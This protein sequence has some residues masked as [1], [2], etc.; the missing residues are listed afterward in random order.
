MYSVS[1]AY[2][3]QMMKNAT[4][5]RLTGTIGSVAFT[6]DDVV[7]GSFE[8]SGAATTKSDTKIGGVYIGELSFMFV[9][10]FLD[11]VARNQYK[12]KEI[13]VSIGLM[14][15]GSWIDI[16]VGVYT[17]QAPKISKRGIEITAY[18][19]MAKLDKKFNI[20]ATSA[21]PWGYLSY[22]ATHCSV[23]LGITRAEV[24]A[25]PNGTELLGLYQEN[26]IET[27]RDLLYWVA[28]TLGC[29]ACCD[30]QGQI[31]LRKFG[32]PTGVTFDSDHRD[33]DIVF[34][35]YETKWTGVSFV[36]IET[37]MTRYYGLEVDD[38]LTMNMGANPLLQVGSI[39]AINRRRINVLNAVAQIRYTPFSMNAAR[40]PIFD[41]GDE[42][43]FEGGISGDCTGCVMAYEYSLD[44]FAFEGYGDDPALANAR[45]KTD[46]NI[47]GLMQNTTENEVTYHQYVNLEAITF[48]SDQEVSL[49]KLR[50]VSAQLTTVKILHE[51]IFDMLSD[52][53]S[54]GSYELHYYLDGELLAYKPGERT[55]GIYG[56][57][58]GTSEFS[59]CRDFFYVI[60]DVEPGL[61]HTWEVKIITHGINLT[62]IDAGNAHVVLEG[63]RM[64]GEDYFGG[65][66]EAE[67]VIIATALGYLAVLP[68]CD[69]VTLELLN[70]VF[71]AATD[72][73]ELIDV[74]SFGLIQIREG[75]GELSPHIFFEG[76]L[77][78]T[79]E[80]GADLTTES[81]VDLITD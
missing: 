56:A 16:P 64:Y 61:S 54:E 20:D 43:L 50:F 27:D 11:K 6:G 35:G 65:V 39:V 28:Q 31:V 8:V 18:D 36:D 45:S 25:L 26:D 55:D 53:A 62:T 40:D 19:H 76:G 63:Q 24:E 44:N 51:F 80:S 71:E 57:T 77:N 33:D 30:R 72:D 59:I 74:N 15:E 42:I 14:V 4:R 78:I 47:A 70:A 5:R 7:R 1:D 46:K 66:I 2:I 17:A 32:N 75:T 13:S 68:I 37:Q 73:F 10:A 60:K 79:T 81:G 69:T 38:G 58:S 12:D 52:L 23:T 48:G 21:T 34:S 67:D 29:F 49:A 9:P 3:T 22:I 41:L